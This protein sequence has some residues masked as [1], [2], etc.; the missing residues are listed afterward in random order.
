[1]Q[2]PPGTGKTATALE[3]L[4]GWMNMMGDLN[5]DNDRVEALF[6][7]GTEWYPGTVRRSQGGSCDIDYDDGDT[8]VG[9]I[10]AHVRPLVKNRKESNN[11]TEVNARMSLKR[12]IKVG[13]QIE[14]RPRGS[15]ASYKPGRISRANGDGTFDI[16]FTDG[17]NEVHADPE[18]IRMQANQ[19]KVAKKKATNFLFRFRC[20]K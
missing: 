13:S 2:G 17:T 15:S 20:F 16:A 19:V 14:A 10:G 1:M 3:I 8:E 7:G 18:R 12:Q 6:R 11:D 5:N 4:E 9:V